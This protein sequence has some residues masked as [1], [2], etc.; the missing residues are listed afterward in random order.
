MDL[1]MI[2]EVVKEE[3]NKQKEVEKKIIVEKELN[4]RKDHIKVN[5]QKLNIKDIKVRCES[6]IIQNK[7]IFS[8]LVDLQRP[9]KS[10]L[11][12]FYS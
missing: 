2:N 9:Q 10:S 3:K 8:N 7:L 4:T 12:G 5:Y 6:G 11:K 1:E